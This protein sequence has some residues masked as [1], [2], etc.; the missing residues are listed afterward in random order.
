MARNNKRARR[1]FSFFDPHHVI[2]RQ[3]VYI[4]LSIGLLAGG[5]TVSQIHYN[6]VRY[7]QLM[8]VD[9]AGATSNFS[10]TNNTTLTLGKTHLSTDNKTAFIPIT[11]SSTD[12]VG[13]KANNYRFYV[14]KSE[15]SGLRKTIN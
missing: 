10:K 15:A 2:E 11:F 12:N 1:S 9:Q 8:K 5:M 7:E 3:T 14:L 6:H 13:I 4:G